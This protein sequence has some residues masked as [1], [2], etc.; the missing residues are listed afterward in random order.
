M[1]PSC[2]LAQQKKAI[3]LLTAGLRKKPSSKRATWPGRSAPLGTPAYTS[4]YTPRST[5]APVG[6]YSRT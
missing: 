3:R 1:R 6:P 2:T 4:S 5:L